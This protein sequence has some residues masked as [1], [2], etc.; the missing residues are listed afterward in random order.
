M[1]KQNTTKK[2]QVKA[3]LFSGTPGEVRTPD[4]Q[5]RSLPLYPL[6]YGRLIQPLKTKLLYTT[7]AKKS[8]SLKIILPL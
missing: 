3:C 4:A 2:R 7:K 8:S 1:K 6:S 5:I